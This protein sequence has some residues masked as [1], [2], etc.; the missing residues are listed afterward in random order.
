[1][2]Y[3]ESD[4]YQTDETCIYCDYRIN[5]NDEVKEEAITIFNEYNEGLEG[6]DRACHWDCFID[7]AIE[8]V[9]RKYPNVYVVCDCCYDGCDD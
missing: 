2:E 9:V 6:D 3:R 5:Y 7:E 8:K 1:M 4:F